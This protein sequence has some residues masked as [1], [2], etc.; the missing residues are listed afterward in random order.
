MRV[1]IDLF[2]GAGPVDYRPLIAAR[3][4]LK[5]VRKLNEPSQCSFGVTSAPRALDR[6]Q[7]ARVTVADDDGSCYFTGYVTTEPV[8]EYCGT[9]TEGPA[10]NTIITALSDEVLLDKQTLL[11]RNGQIGQPVSALM[12][13][14]AANG[15]S[16]I[17]DT[18]GVVAQENVGH[19][20]PKLSE[21][22]SKNA[23]DLAGLARAG[24]RVLDGKLSLTPI[25]TPVHEYNEDDGTL[26]SE[27]L[28]MSRSKSLINDVTLCGEIEPAM[29]ATEFFLGD[30]I[31][32][33]FDLNDRPFR[34]ALS[35]STT[36]EDEFIGSA[37]DSRIWQIADP[38]SHFSLSAAGLT[39]NGGS[40]LVGQT[41]VVAKNAVE[42]GGALLVE[43]TGVMLSTASDGL[44]LALCKGAVRE[45]NCFAGFR[46]KQAAGNV[47]IVPVVAGTENGASYA[48]RSGSLYTLRIRVYCAEHQRVQESFYSA[49]DDGPTMFGGSLNAA[50]ANLLLEIQEI[51]NG[52]PAPAVVLYDGSVGQAPAVCD[53]LLVDSSNISGSLKSVRVTTPTGA[54]VKTCPAGGGWETKRIGASSADGDCIVETS[55][56]VRFYPTAIPRNGECVSVRYRTGK[57]SIARVSQPQWDFNGVAISSCSMGT[58]TRPK[59]RSSADCEN[60]AIALLNSSC[61]RSSAIAGEYGMN[62]LEGAA[63]SGEDVWPGD[64]LA[65]TSP[66]AALDAEVVVREVRM[67]MLSVSPQVLQYKIDFANDWA[68]ELSLKVSAS[69]PADASVPA[70]ANAATIN[71]LATLTLSVNGANIAVDAGVTPPPGGGFEVRRRDWAFGPGTNSDL[72]LR[73]PVQH[74]S[75]PRWAACERYY[76]RMYDGSAPPA[77][78]R[79]SSGIFLNLPM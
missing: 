24:Y 30:G 78:S 66:S 59:A 16:A 71:N 43:A 31:T 68:Q 8:L 34:A 69:V 36:I 46:V 57:R 28:T 26:S 21:T 37:I 39:I 70:P 74:F 20:V 53:L 42:I 27:S 47:S 17:F 58:L 75:I 18:T 49:G 51:I 62:V 35:N 3:H 79:F 40:G 6:S 25:G 76:V 13:T 10:Y 77:Y 45:S 48:V 2:D 67:E 12:T 52:I 29:F 41:N 64:A 23:G 73:S 55:G 44:L 50:G 63:E 38:G 72:V 14:L 65:I 19:F 32:S 54:W 22:W 1:T 9:G 33:T 15:G 5:V 61:S 7:N 4:P 11:A 56:S 60:G